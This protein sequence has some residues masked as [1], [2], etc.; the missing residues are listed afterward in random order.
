M[1]LQTHPQQTAAT[2]KTKKQGISELFL[3]KI[4]MTQQL[5][6]LPPALKLV[7]PFIKHATT[8]GSAGDPAMGYYC[9]GYEFISLFGILFCGRLTY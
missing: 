4:L 1:Q 2:T 5:P 8:L 9:T 3:F 6:P 7:A